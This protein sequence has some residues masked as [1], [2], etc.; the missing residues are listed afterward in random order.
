MINIVTLTSII[1]MMGGTIIRTSIPVDTSLSS[2]EASVAA[3]VVATW[4][5]Y[6]NCVSQLLAVCM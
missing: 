1:R 3:P 6:V 2:D 4:C 5:T